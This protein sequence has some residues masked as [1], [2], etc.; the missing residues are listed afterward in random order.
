MK[1]KTTVRTALLFALS[2]SPMWALAEDTIVLHSLGAAYADN[3][4]DIGIAPLETMYGDNVEDTGGV[5]RERI[6]KNEGS[7][8]WAVDSDEG[9]AEVRHPLAALKAESNTDDCF[10]DY[11]NLELGGPDDC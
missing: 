1:G 5:F 2:F 11:T 4:E 10:S 9:S 7:G 8:D 6:Q 3:V